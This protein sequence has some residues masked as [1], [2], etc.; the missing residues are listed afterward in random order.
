M[1]IARNNVFSA[2]RGVRPVDIR[3]AVLVAAAQIGWTVG[4]S[5]RQGG[6][7]SSCWWA[8]SCDAPTHL[9]LA[10]IALLALGAG[11]LLSRRLYP[12]AVLASVFA[13]TLLYVALGYVQGPNYAALA[14]AF[15]T[16]VIAGDRTAAAVALVAAWVL[17]L[18]LPDALG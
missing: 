3:I 15:V 6:G 7:R 18:W 9:N 1:T 14:V 10:A 8:S 13:V 5:H 12:R 2:L 16:V 11:A 4:A 17:F